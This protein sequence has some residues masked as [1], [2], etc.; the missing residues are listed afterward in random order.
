MNVIDETKTKMGARFLSTQ[1]ML[2][3]A[4]A[5]L[6][7]LRL[8]AVQEAMEGEETCEEIR[9]I[10]KDFGDMDRITARFSLSNGLINNNKATAGW[11]F[12]RCMVFMT[13]TLSCLLLLL[14]LVFLSSSSC[15]EQ[16]NQ[17]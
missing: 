6:I 12:F 9:R 7:G 8:D 2:P 4:D 3:L 10:L 15:N 1:L 17:K 5:G 14:L 11:F 16:F 13:L